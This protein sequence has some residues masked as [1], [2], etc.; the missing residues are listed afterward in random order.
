M[1]ASAR[2]SRV[3]ASGA[4]PPAVSSV[5]AESF[6]A[7]RSSRKFHLVTCRFAAAIKEQNRVPLATR[8][9]AAREGFEPCKKCL[10]SR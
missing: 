3:E 9:A 2:P 6:V 4:P 5:P 1:P 7:N 8:E 10:P